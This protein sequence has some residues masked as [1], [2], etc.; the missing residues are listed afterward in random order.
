M[1]RD[2]RI[3]VKVRGLVFAPTEPGA[4]TNPLNGI[5]ASLFCNGTPAGTTAAFPFSPQG[6][7][8]IR[9]QLPTPPKPCVNPTVLLNPAPDGVVNSA[10]YIASSVPTTRRR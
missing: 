9:A 10:T 4:G 8:R 1:R 6:D 3:R 2:G 5:A 7:A